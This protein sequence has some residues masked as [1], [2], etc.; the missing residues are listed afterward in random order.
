[1]RLAEVPRVRRQ[2]FLRFVLPQQKMLP[3]SNRRFCGLYQLGRGSSR[4]LSYT[5]ADLG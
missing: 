1:M 5:V 3:K 4:M 2:L